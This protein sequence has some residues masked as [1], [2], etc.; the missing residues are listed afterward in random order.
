MGGCESV[1]KGLN[2]WNDDTKRE[3]ASLLSTL[4]ETKN[5][6][7]QTNTLLS[8]QIESQESQNSDH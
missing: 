6:T 8:D 1:I 5:S 2:E 3:N 4:D 7:L